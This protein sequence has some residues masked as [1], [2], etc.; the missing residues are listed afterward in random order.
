[1]ANPLRFAKLAVS[2][3]A[4]LAVLGAAA[5]CGPCTTIG[6]AEGLTIAFAKFEAGKTYTIVVSKVS[7]TS[8]EV[9]TTCEAKAATEPDA[10]TTLKC[11]P[12]QVV[13]TDHGQLRFADY[14]DLKK[15]KV[16]ISES[17]TLLVEQTYEPDYV[18]AEINGKTCGTCTTVSIVV[19]FPRD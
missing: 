19:D 13:H 10:V 3:A 6:C 17:G 5:G 14:Q 15:V 7:S 18:T 11:E 8:E 4:A 12:S 9:V 16:A 1:M 2:A